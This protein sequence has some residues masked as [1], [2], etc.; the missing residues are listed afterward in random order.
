MA[1]RI[2][3]STAEMSA[4]IS[5]YETA[6]GTLQDAFGKLQAAREHLDSCYKGPAYMA[7]CA[8]WADIYLNVKTA[9]RAIDDSVNGLRKT[10]TEM[11]QAESNVS[12]TATS[13]EQGSDAP[14]YL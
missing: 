3:V 11:D 4:T 2:L 12:S 10:I 13:L 8:K 9:E 1:D 6:R 5:K 7:L 14:T